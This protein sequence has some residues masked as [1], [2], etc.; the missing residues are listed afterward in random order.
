LRITGGEG[1]VGYR[2]SAFSYTGWMLKRWL[3]G[4]E[5]REKE[6]LKADS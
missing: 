5:G 1:A 4:D 3:D 2:L 6:K